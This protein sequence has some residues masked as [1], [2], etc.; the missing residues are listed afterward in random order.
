MRRAIAS[1]FAAAL[2]DKSR[3]IVTLDSRL[4]EDP[5]PWSVER[6][7]PGQVPE[8]FRAIARTA[9]FTVLI[10]PETTGILARLT[11]EFLSDGARVLG[12]SPEAIDLTGNK[13]RLSHWLHEH[14][15]A[16]PRSRIVSPAL[17]L[18][19]DVDYPAVLKPVDGAGSVDTFYLDGGDS[20]P[21][22]AR[23]L[24]VALLQP[25]VPG[26]PMS[27]SYLVDGHGRARLIATGTQHMSIQD[28]LFRYRGGTLPSSCSPA[29]PQ[30]R[31]AVESIP[32]LRGFVGIDF[33]WDADRGR[34]T[35]LEINPRPT[36]SYVGLIRLLPP[37]RLA[38]AWLA[39]FGH[40]MADVEPPGDLSEMIRGRTP[41]SFDASGG[42]VLECGVGR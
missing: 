23:N 9:D 3:V 5:G 41:L 16:T 21:D 24:T 6:I 19:A 11:R 18:P 37:G 14:G 4:P 29:E 30:L 20:L 15:I 32:G 42:V 2:G 35:V 1:D 36:T 12:S 7:K 17:D 39:A 22:C 40:E 10:A 31:R 27:A 28:G 8:R 25:F 26:V 33:V 38:T 13:L 34:E